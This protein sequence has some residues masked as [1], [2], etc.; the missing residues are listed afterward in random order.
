MM[1]I[2]MATMALL[3]TIIG[4]CNGR[5]MF[6]QETSNNNNSDTTQQHDTRDDIGP[7]CLLG[8]DKECDDGDPC[9][10]ETCVDRQCVRKD[11]ICPSGLMCNEV[12]ECVAVEHD[13][14]DTD[15]SNSCTID[16]CDS[17][18]GQALHVERSCDDGDPSTIDSCE[19][20]TGGCVHAPTDCHDD[21]ACT[22]DHY[23][24]VTSACVHE[25]TAC[26]DAYACVDGTCQ[27]Q[28]A[29][30]SDCSDGNPCTI[31]SCDAQ[32]GACSNEVR[33]CSD[34]EATTTD[35]CLPE[36]DGEGKPYTC[37]HFVTA[38]VGG[39]WDNNPCTL[40]FCLFGGGCAHVWASCGDGTVCDMDS[41]QCVP[42]PCQGT[43]DCD[44]GNPCTSETCEYGTCQY[45]QIE[46]G[47]GQACDAGTGECVQLG[48]ADCPDGCDD[49]NSA[50]LD[51][52][53]SGMCQHQQPIECGAG[54][55]LN[56]ITGKC[57]PAESDVEC[58][59]GTVTC[60]QF[61]NLHLQTVSTCHNGQWFIL[62]RCGDIEHALCVGASCVDVP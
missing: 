16:S 39:C 22:H 54:T 50:T 48:G 28:C 3:M 29:T 33:E 62:E 1:K 61:E 18:T 46:C 56:P 15:D 55:A 38:C 31:D 7:G 23:D 26:P 34:G 20:A 36:P 4:A 45:T 41:G 17:L 2:K 37:K 27:F 44:D 30:H 51:Y 6:G 10:V 24:V 58:V 11:V 52:C 25:P 57:E 12:G 60:R 14:G 13:C 5:P 21:D 40:D 47:A 42:A 59:D 32:T 49:H 9:T 35:V 53:E 19:E 43:P 8:S